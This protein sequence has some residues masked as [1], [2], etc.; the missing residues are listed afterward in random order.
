MGARPSGLPHRR[1]PQKRW[2]SATENFMQ[3]PLHV[4]YGLID[5]RAPGIVAE[6]P[7][8]RLAAAGALLLDYA[9]MSDTALADALRDHAVDAGSRTLFAIA[10]QLDDATLPARWKT[11]LVPWL[12]SPAFAVDRA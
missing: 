12:K 3:E 10:E 5:E 2:L 6:S 1:E 4:L 11:L 8:A 7:E 9:R